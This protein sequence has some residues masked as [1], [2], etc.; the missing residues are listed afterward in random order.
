M[1]IF[2]GADVSVLS[3]VRQTF[4]AW[5][6]ENVASLLTTLVFL[7]SFSLLVLGV[8][9]LG[10]VGCGGGRSLGKGRDLPACVLQ[11]TSVSNR[12]S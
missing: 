3:V 2:K 4:S 11:E 5:A 7:L 12:I 9:T 8:R 10:E 6:K 1:S